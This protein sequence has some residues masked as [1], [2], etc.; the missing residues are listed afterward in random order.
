M[1][2]SSSLWLGPPNSTSLPWCTTRS[3]MAA[4]SLS[5]AKTVP[6]L[7]NST[8]VVNIT[9]LPPIAVRGLVQEPRPVHVE[10]HVAELVQ[11]Q[12]PRLGRVGERPVERPLPLG[13]AELQHQLRDLPEPHKVA[14]RGRGDPEGGGHVDLTAPRLAVEGQVLRVAHER[15]L[16][17]LVAAPAVG[18]RDVGPVEA[19]DRHVNGEPCLPG[20]AR[21]LRPVAVRDLRPELRRARGHL[22]L[23]RGGEMPGESVFVGSQEIIYLPNTL[24]ARV[25]LRNSRIRQV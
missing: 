15:Q 8:L 21:P 11:D 23:R 18:V 5:S 17:H 16:G 24:A 14:R 10:G 6:H 25:M 19:L 22:A 9:L 13:L 20:Q 7:L 1:R 4:A 2:D 12:E 3:T